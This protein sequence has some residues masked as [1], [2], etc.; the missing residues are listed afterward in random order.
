MPDVMICLPTLT[1]RVNLSLMVAVSRKRWP[2]TMLRATIVC[3]RDSAV[4]RYSQR[5]CS[6]SSPTTNGQHERTVDNRSVQRLVE[7]WYALFEFV[8]KQPHVVVSDYRRGVK[9]QNPSG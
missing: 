5:K 9:G 1:H 4:A 6:W 2:G 8:E 3:R 7:V